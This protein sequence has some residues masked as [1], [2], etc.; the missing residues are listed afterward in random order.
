MPF[1]RHVVPS[2][3][4]GNVSDPVPFTTSTIENYIAIVQ[5]ASGSPSSIGPEPTIILQAAAGPDLPV[6]YIVDYPDEGIIFDDTDVETRRALADVA[7]NST[8]VGIL[9]SP[10]VQG[11]N[12]VYRVYIAVYRAGDLDW[13]LKIENNDDTNAHAYHVV[14]ADTEAEALQAWIDV[15]NSTVDVQT[16]INRD[17]T[18]TLTVVNK[19]TDDLIIES[20]TPDLTSEFTLADPLPITLVPNQSQNLTINFEA[21]SEP[22]SSDGVI[23]LPGIFNTGTDD[24]TG[25]IIGRDEAAGEPGH[26]NTFM[27]SSTTHALEIAMVLDDSGSMSWDEDGSPLPAGSVLSRW[28]ELSD[29]AN[30]FLDLLAAFGFSTTSTPGHHGRFGVARFQPKVPGDPSSR[31]IV[32]PQVITG[33]GT[34]SSHQGEISAVEPSGSTYM[35]EGV[36]RVVN[37]GT[38]YFVDD[39]TPLAAKRRGIILMS[40]GDHNSGIHPRDL[41]PDLLSRHIRVFSAGYGNAAAFGVNQDL[42]NELADGSYEGGY[43]ARF[44]DNEG[45]NALEMAKAFRTALK[46]GLTE[47]SSPSD[48]RGVIGNGIHEQRH[49]VTITPYD[50]KAVFVLHWNT[51]DAK[52]LSLELFTPT[53][54]RIDQEFV[55]EDYDYESGTGSGMKEGIWFSSGNRYQMFTIDKKFLDNVKGS[56]PRYGTWTLMVRASGLY[57]EQAETYEY[58]VIVDSRLQMKVETV[59]Q[60]HFT[61]EP[62]QLRASITLDGLPIPN[63]SVTLQAAAPGNSINNWLAGNVVTEEEYSAA[64]D[65]LADFP[66]I[67]PLDIKAYAL[68][69]KQKEFN[70]IGKENTLPMPFANGMYSASVTDTAA[71]ETYTFYV[72]AVGVTDDGEFFRREKELQVYVGVKPEAERTIIDVDYSNN[73]KLNQATICV[74][75]QDRYGNAILIDPKFSSLIQLMNSGGQFIDTLTS[76]LDGS[77]QQTLE[78]APDEQPTITVTV[79]G[80]VVTQV[81]P[82]LAIDDLTYVDTVLDFQIGGEATPDANEHTDPTAALGVVTGNDDFVSLGR[83][84]VLSLGLKDPDVLI[85]AQ[86]KDDITVFVKT[87][88]DL[89]RYQVEVQPVDRDEWI[90]LGGSSGT[91]QSFSLRAVGLQQARA[92]RI[93]DRSGKIVDSDGAP[94]ATPGVSIL[95]VGFHAVGPLQQQLDIIIRAAGTVQLHSE[96]PQVGTLGNIE[97]THLDRESGRVTMTFDGYDP[98]RSARYV[99]KALTMFEHDTGDSRIHVVEFVRF[100]QEGFTL[101]MHQLPSAQAT[102]APAC[103][104]EISEIIADLAS[105]PPASNVLLEEDFTDYGAGENPNYWVDTGP[106]YSLEEADSFGTQEISDAMAFGTAAPEN[107][108]HTHYIGADAH[109]WSNYLFTGQLYITEESSG[110]GVTFYSQ[111]PQADTY[112]VLRRFDSEKNPK[113]AGFHVVARVAGTE[114]DLP[115][116][117]ITDV[118]PKAETW[119]NFHIEVSSTEKVT[120][121]RGKVWQEHGDEPDEYGIDT[122]LTDQ[123]R[124]DAGTVGMW[125][126]GPGE[127]YIRN[128]LVQRIG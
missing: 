50:T 89:R 35:G 83:Y 94:L 19:G 18:G 29:A 53:C 127:K 36:R 91:T 46:S 65:A 12:G 85:T 52:L 107:H 80:N 40:D 3:L 27:L 81:P 61:G 13:T 102:L 43:G 128:L 48:P 7:L 104:I 4:A 26:N 44:A 16:L 8:E 2:V 115:A 74:R 10:F 51:P 59:A 103:M 49:Q 22:P 86:G 70:R 67:T 14:V 90:L 31:D 108:I 124:L 113:Q 99:V 72:T 25:I 88:S 39:A 126:Q 21:P 120:H 47:T 57:I 87:D 118:E 125:T 1:T 60:E 100:E 98:Q 75:P 114:H 116:V 71:P 34:M 15:T 96:G 76:K 92:V 84:G 23:N 9:A 6:G 82:I 45:L 110:I 63:A 33:P 66:D 112:Y 24:G 78:Y 55:Y 54:D 121:I 77:Y 101:H 41:L 30:E 97:V 5:L 68:R 62:I 56:Y 64:A 11:T 32:P 105:G 28:H 122:Q 73:G 42:L 109:T 58:D 79:G 95:G 106:D 119:Y 117:R 17:V 37:L 38:G 123:R 20:T 93:Q 69:Q 111:Y